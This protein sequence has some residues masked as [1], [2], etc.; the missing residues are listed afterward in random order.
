MRKVKGNGTIDQDC[1][2]ELDYLTG[3]PTTANSTGDRWYTGI[4]KGESVIVHHTEGTPSNACTTTVYTPQ[5]V[6]N[7]FSWDW[8][9]N[10][11]FEPVKNWAE[12]N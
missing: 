10:P 2:F 6:K 8:D 9:N 12:T 4:E 7:I 5:E 11:S 3:T 1:G